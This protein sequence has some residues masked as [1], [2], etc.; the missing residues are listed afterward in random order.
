MIKVTCFGAARS[1][2][3]S[4]Y[5]IETSSGARFLVDCGLF[6]GSREI[7]RHNWSDWGYH[8]ER[9]NNLILT[10]AHIDHSGRIP[11][12]VND[13]FRGRIITSPP[14]A[15]LCRV[16]LLDSAHV[17]EMEAEWQTRKNRRQAKNSILPL[18]NKLDAEK[19]LEFLYP[20]ELD[21][22]IELEPGVKVRLRNSGHVLGSC[23]VEIWIE[24]G[25]SETKIVFSGDLGKQDQLIV[26][27]PFKIGGADYLF[28]ESTY[29]N[30]LHRNF[31]DSK[32]EFLQA[33]QYAVSNGEKV[34]IPAF[35]LERT[36]EILYLLGEFSRSKMIPPIP[37]FLDSPL[38]IRA[39][40]IFRKNK[41]YFDEDTQS[42]VGKGV[43]PFDIPNLKMTLTAPESMKINDY[44]GS[45]IIISANGMCSAGRI[46]HHLKHNLWR[47]G[48]SLVIVGFQGE[49][50]TGRQIVEGAKSVR[51]FGEKVAVRAKVFTIGGFSAH[52][53]QADLLNWISHFQDKPAPKVFVIHGE[54][55]VIDV[56]SNR[57][58]KTFGFEVYTPRM[59]ELLILEDGKKVSEIMPEIEPIEAPA[60]NVELA[61]ELETQINILK[62]RLSAGLKPISQ[63]DIER[64]R[65]IRDELSTIAEN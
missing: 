59:R 5:L 17:Q 33:I 6:Q 25:S 61:I 21:Q 32:A 37:I 11:K 62:N 23:A 12:L 51:I 56:F 8:P 57:I 26:K 22:I 20:V 15:E 16:M 1:V 60:D 29:G 10:H 42:L 7:E 19:S 43:D 58:R 46:K 14:T 3:G 24:N 45:A 39:T 55:T 41:K 36:Q 35:A 52:A 44:K 4:N 27:D 54:P 13:G 28:I 63:E 53:D 2:T 47:P 65:E 30:R 31:E 64:L 38:A 40:E 48:A 18:Y 50:T 49:G 9:I 34:I